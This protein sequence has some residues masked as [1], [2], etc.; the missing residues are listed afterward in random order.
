MKFPY[1]KYTK[2]YLPIIP[3]ELRGK[4]EW[5]VFDAYLDSGAGFSIFHSD[6][7]AILDIVIEDGRES[8]VVIGDGSKIKVYLHYLEIRIANKEFK[9][10][11]GFSHHLGIGFNILGQEGIFDKFRI[12]FDRND[13][14]IEFYPILIEL[15]QKR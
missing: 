15:E 9:A 13:R 11:I 4:E 8:F 3:I 7:A 10:L 5:V 1:I 6:V 2:R 12:C 14:C